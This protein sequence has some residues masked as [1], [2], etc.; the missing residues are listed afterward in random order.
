MACANNGKTSNRK[1]SVLWHDTDRGTLY[2]QAFDSLQFSD[3]ILIMDFLQT[4]LLEEMQDNPPQPASP[5]Q[6]A[7]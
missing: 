4:L 3:K 2:A 6:T 5:L 1:G 7:D